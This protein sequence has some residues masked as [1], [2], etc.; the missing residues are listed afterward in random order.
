MKRISNLHRMAILSVAAV[1]IFG[2]PNL[3]AAEND[4]HGVTPQ[5]EK[6]REPS[7][8]GLVE[9]PA[10]PD[11]TKFEVYPL[12]N[13]SPETMSQLLMP[14]GAHVVFEDQPKRMIV[15]GPEMLQKMV[16][17]LIQKL[18][19]SSQEREKQIKVFRLM[20][21]DPQ[22]TAKAI[23]ELNL[24][25]RL[26]IDERTQSFIATSD[27]PQAISTVAE[28]VKL[29]DVPNSRQSSEGY[30]VR[31]VWLAGGLPADK[32]GDPPAEDL[33]GVAAELSRLGIKD[34]SQ[35]GQMAVQV[36]CENSFNIKSSPRF[37]DQMTELEASGILYKMSQ[38]ELR[39]HID[40]RTKRVNDPAEQYLNVFS[41]EIVMPLNRYVVLATAPVGNQTSVFVV[42]V[43]GGAKVEEKKAAR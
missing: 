22:S 18:D 41:T 21:A 25:V 11:S 15:F 29:F 3:P 33:K 19:S 32:R 12:Q 28:L 5:G 10:D 17:K 38:G 20:Y 26:G 42:Q 4:D 9:T 37:D 13:V 31:V 24:G 30:E 36:S 23:E 34:P 8:D 16:A 27:S 1:S 43:T 14:L 6:I 35:V 40:I 39:M 2:L 7:P